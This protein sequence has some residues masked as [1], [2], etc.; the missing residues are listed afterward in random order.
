M[1][2]RSLRTV[3]EDLDDAEQMALTEIMRKMDSGDESLLTD[4]ELTL[5]DSLAPSGITNVIEAQDHYANLA[6]YMEDRDLNLLAVQVDDWFEQDEIAVRHRH[7]D[8]ALALYLMGLVDRVAQDSE[9]SPYFEH[10]SDEFYEKLCQ[11]DEEP[12]EGASRVHHPMLLMAC[13]QFVARAMGEVWPPDGPVKTTVMGA[14]DDAVN[15]QAQRVQNYMNYQY[16]VLIEDAFADTEKLLLRLAMSGSAFT[17]CF[18]D[19]VREQNT[20]RY[21]APEDFFVPYSATTLET[22]Q[23]Y[24]EVVRMSRGELLRHIESGF[25]RQIRLPQATNDRGQVDETVR[26]TADLVEGKEQTDYDNDQR[27][28]LLEMHVELDLADYGFAMDQGEKDRRDERAPLPYIVTIDKEHQKVL[29]VYRNWQV[30]DPRQ[31]K[32]VYYTHY[33]FMPGLGFYGLGYIQLLRGLTKA[34]TGSLRSLL[35]AASF[36]NMKGGYRST[37]VKMPKDHHGI[38]APGEMVPVD[39]TAEELQRAFY[40]LQWGEPSPTMFQLMQYMEQQGDQLGNVADVLTGAAKNTAPVGTTMALVE[41]ALVPY[42]AVHKRVFQGNA[43]EFRVMAVLNGEYIPAGGYPYRVRDADQIIYAQDFDDRVDVIPVAD[44]QVVTGAQRV[45][46][47]QALLEMARA[48][49]ANFNLPAIY[50]RALLAMRIPNPDEV[51]QQQAQA[52]RRDAITEN[53]AMLRAQPVQ[54]FPLQDH[55]AHI[56][57]HA[58]MFDALDPAAQRDIENAYNAHIADHRAQAYIDQMQ[59]QLG[60]A[61]PEGELTPEQ[62]MQLTRAATATAPDLLVLPSAPNDAQDAEIARKD[63]EVQAEIAR[64]DRESAAEIA[65]RDAQ[66]AAEV[67]RRNIRAL[68]NINN[69]GQRG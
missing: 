26:D 11:L 12:F 60:M 58:A 20:R 34:V 39:A 5:L 8:D 4:E 16:T 48:D 24:T 13:I 53:A 17:K 25:Y 9:R 67:Q 42:S 32:R 44:P 63:L 49:P 40:M 62:D 37:D 54:A 31:Q 43:H 52:Q 28:V 2:S 59:A 33:R 1:A 51:L 69:R 35:D 41:Q 3:R 65:R 27:H 30:D 46:Q 10:C 47:A 22:A 57:V 66:A 18:H 19:P 15:A 50:R 6:E 21:V 68:A 61:L 23:R 56:A 38:I 36:S 29:S 45:T 55:G 7:E 14:V 64:E